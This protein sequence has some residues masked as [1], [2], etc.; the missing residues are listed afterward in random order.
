MWMVAAPHGPPPVKTQRGERGSYLVFNPTVWEAEQKQELEILYEDI[1]VA[2]R[3]PRPPRAP[4]NAAAANGPVQ[5]NPQQQPGQQPQNAVGTQPP[6][7][8]SQHQ[9]TNSSSGVALPVT[10]AQA[11]PATGQTAA[12][13]A[14]AARA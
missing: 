2:P 8:G 7:P 1:E 9:S 5:G 4:G 12:A 10:P 6:V 13:A 3:L 14:G 11:A